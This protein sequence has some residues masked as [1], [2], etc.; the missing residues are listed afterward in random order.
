MATFANGMQ[1]VLVHKTSH[2]LVI[3]PCRQFYTQPFRLLNALFGGFIS[4]VGWIVDPIIVT[5]LDVF[6]SLVF[7]LFSPFFNRRFAHP[8]VG[9]V[10]HYFAVHQHDQLRTF[11]PHVELFR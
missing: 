6:S 11:V 2:L 9:T 1:L 8:V 5:P 10:R 4:C 7:N 3:L